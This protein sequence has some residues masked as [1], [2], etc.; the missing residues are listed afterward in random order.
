[1]APDAYEEEE[2]AARIPL[3]APEVEDLGLDAALLSVDSTCNDVDTKQDCDEEE[4]AEQD[5]DE[6]E[7]EGCAARVVADTAAG[8]SLGAAKSSARGGSEC[9]RQLWFLLDDMQAPWWAAMEVGR[10]LTTGLILGFRDNNVRTCRIQV[11]LLAAQALAMFVLAVAIRPFGSVASNFFLIVA[12]LGALLAAILIA[13]QVFDLSSASA[14]W[15]EMTTLVFG[16]IATL[17]TVLQLIVASRSLLASSRAICGQLLVRSHV[18]RPPLTA[19]L[20]RFPYPS[21][22]Q[23]SIRAT[24][25]SCRRR[26]SVKGEEVQRRTQR[27]RAKPLCVL[28]QPLCPPC[29]P[30]PP[31]SMT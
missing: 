10:L 30:L 2:R 26:T 1:V 29:L 8:T 7:E 23:T 6:E 18:A 28:K 16:A 17:Q 25:T 11:C 21:S 12:N 5:D 31:T 15:A 3:Q 9:K 4:E 20:L 19:P 27:T 13:L 14:E 24:R 22:W